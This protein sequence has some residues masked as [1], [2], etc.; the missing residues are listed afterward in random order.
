MGAEQNEV[1]ESKQQ[2]LKIPFDELEESIKAD[3]GITLSLP[4]ACEIV[5]NNLYLFEIP[6]E[7]KEAILAVLEQS[8]IEDCSET[9]EKSPPQ[10]ST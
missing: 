2:C 1:Q 6:A 8:S 7:N 9:S 10:K 5:K 4:E 3:H